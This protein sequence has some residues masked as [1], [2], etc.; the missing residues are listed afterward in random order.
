MLITYHQASIQ[1]LDSFLKRLCVSKQF[2]HTQVFF[3]KHV[4]TIPLAQKGAY[5]RKNLC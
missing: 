1:I 3:R 4:V 2:S 5:A